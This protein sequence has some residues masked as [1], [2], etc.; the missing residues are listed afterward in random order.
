MV[1]FMRAFTA[2]IVIL[3]VASSTQSDPRP[4]L[5]GD[6]LPVLAVL[7]VFLAAVVVATRRRAA[8]DRYRPLLVVAA[9]ALGLMLLQPEGAG[10]LALYM[11]LGIV[12]VQLGPRYA[13][14]G[15]VV[16]V[17]IISVVHALVDPG[18]SVAGIVIGDAVGTLFFVM[19]Y[20]MRAARRQVVELEATRE[21]HA[22]AA[23]LRERA[24]LAREMHDV[25][26]H[27]LSALAVQLEGARLLARTRGA[28]PRSPRRSSAGTASPVQAWRRH[29][30]RSRRCAAATCRGPT[31]SERSRR[32]FASRRTSR[33]P[34]RWTASR[35]S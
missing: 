9:S 34:W 19:G 13:L 29:G 20:S 16:G 35:A 25:L 4:S 21:A 31:A 6:G 33:A 27:S 23:A 11:T 24:R 5:H 2:L 28:D 15:F 10:F 17:V 12:C 32:R 18:S 14:G 26:A 30:G 7:T 1:G 22:Q 8:A 3:V